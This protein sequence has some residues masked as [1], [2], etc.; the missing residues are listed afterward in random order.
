MALGV[1]LNGYVIDTV[2]WSFSHLW[3]I[4]S[5]LQMF[6]EK[7]SRWCFS[8]SLMLAPL[9][10]QW[11]NY[12][13][14]KNNL[15]HRHRVRP[16]FVRQQSTHN[17]AIQCHSLNQTSYMQLACGEIINTS[18]RQKSNLHHRQKIKKLN[19]GVLIFTTTRGHLWHRP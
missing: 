6:Q 18:P 13:N 5:W 17:V 2:L 9:C 16:G 15:E 11:T 12:A 19:I 4:F 1:L 3:T 8:H 10:L 14:R 7:L